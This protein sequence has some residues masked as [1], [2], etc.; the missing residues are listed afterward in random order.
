MDDP[1]IDDDSDMDVGPNLGDA[2]NKNNF[3]N[4][5]AF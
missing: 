2:L 5:N 3:Q 1:Q 4:R